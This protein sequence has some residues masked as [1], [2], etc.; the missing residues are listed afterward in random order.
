MVWYSL[1][2]NAEALLNTEPG[3]EWQKL[4]LYTAADLLVPVSRTRLNETT[5]I[6]R[7]VNFIHPK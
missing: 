6:K 1:H 4:S 5:S 2:V 7:L 3:G